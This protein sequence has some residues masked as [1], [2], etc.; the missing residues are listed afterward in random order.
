MDC[1]REIP[2]EYRLAYEHGR[3]FNAM[4][5]AI[6]YIKLKMPNEARQIL[7]RELKKSKSEY[8]PDGI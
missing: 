6:N 7:E 3:F 2:E 4:E 5:T 1:E 8:K